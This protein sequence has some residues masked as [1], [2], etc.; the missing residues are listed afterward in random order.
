MIHQSAL[1]KISI[2]SRSETLHCRKSSVFLMTDLDE[3]Y[4]KTQLSASQAQRFSIKIKF[5]ICYHP[6]CG[7]RHTCNRRCV[8]T[9]ALS[10]PT[11]KKVL[12]KIFLLEF[13]HPTYVRNSMPKRVKADKIQKTH[14][15][16]S[17][18]RA[19]ARVPH[20]VIRQ[21][22]LLGK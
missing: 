9:L 20:L 15:L 10:S 2:F 18:V 7:V 21:L 8:Q 22:Q 13:V 4:P 14:V 11:P 12:V 1:I 3:I 5:E 17:T 16:R 19:M 6:G